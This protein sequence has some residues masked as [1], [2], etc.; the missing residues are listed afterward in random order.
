MG[1]TLHKKSGKWQAQASHNQKNIYLGLYETKEEAM[2]KVSDY[3]KKTPTF[4][5]KTY[6][7]N[8]ELYKEIIYSKAIGSLTP[9]A[10][11]MLYKMV[12]RIT[13][14]FRYKDNQDMEDVRQYSV[15]NL[16]KNWRSFDQYGYDNPFSYYSELIKRSIAM[17]YRVNIKENRRHISIE[18]TYE[19]GTLNI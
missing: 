13:I 7:D 5:L 2:K 3:I 11:E 17:E 9:K 12:N 18:R 15:L 4:L 14:K 6:V 8:V 1:V 19:N 16:L 10:F